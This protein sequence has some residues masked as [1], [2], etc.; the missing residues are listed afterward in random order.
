MFIIHEKQ[1]PFHNS[2]GGST[3]NMNTLSLGIKGWRYADLYD[4]LRLKELAEMFYRSVEASD[5]DLGRSY[6]AYRESGGKDLRRRRIE[7][8]R[9][10][11]SPPGPIR[12][13][14][15]S[16][17]AGPLRGSTTGRG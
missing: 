3:R 5:P 14:P 6:A 7:P 12:L 2:L 16:N 1:Y 17:R 11:R 15:L 10:T 8:D 4:P 9:G 13:A